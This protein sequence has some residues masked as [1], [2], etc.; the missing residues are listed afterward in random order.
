M[1]TTAAA[2]NE[3]VAAVVFILLGVCKIRLR[4]IHDA[5]GTDNEQSDGVDK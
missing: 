5:V 1:I 4:E 2:T 3:V